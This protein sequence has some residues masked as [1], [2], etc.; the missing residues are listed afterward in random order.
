MKNFKKNTPSQTSED[1]V[2]VN[3]EVKKAPIIV[4]AE[5]IDLESLNFSPLTKP[6]CTETSLRES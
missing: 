6:V 1:E 5:V 3:L 2:V 4:K